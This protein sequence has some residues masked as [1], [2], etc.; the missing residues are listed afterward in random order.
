ML[1]SINFIVR[2]ESTTR[3]KILC[4]LFETEKKMSNPEGGPVAKGSV[5][6]PFGLIEMHFGLISRCGFVTAEGPEFPCIPK[7]V[8]VV[9]SGTMKNKQVGRIWSGVNPFHC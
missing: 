2:L 8:A 4:I 9:E 7:K 1:L 5:L 6:H 3:C